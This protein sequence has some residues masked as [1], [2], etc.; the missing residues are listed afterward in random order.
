MNEIKIVKF[1]K[2][3]FDREWK[4]NQQSSDTPMAPSRV[5]PSFVGESVFAHLENR[6]KR[7]YTEMK[8]LVAKALTDAGIE[9]T[10]ISWNRYAG[11][12]MCACSGGFIIE[13]HKG[14]DFW[15]EITI[16][17]A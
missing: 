10:K 7:P 15:A 6:R 8:P 13:G 11:C 2:T 3:P 9:F 12:N 5:F 1:E 4:K 16:E 14:Q 17:V